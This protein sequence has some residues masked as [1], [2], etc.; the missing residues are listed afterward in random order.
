MKRQGVGLIIVTASV[1]GLLAERHVG[2]AYVATK[3]AVV[4]LVRHAAIELAEYGVCV[5]GIAPGPILTNIAG[6]KLKDPEVAKPYIA[7]VPMARLGDTDELKGLALLLGSNASS[8]IPGAPIPIDGGMTDWCS[9]HGFWTPNRGDWKLVGEGKS[10]S[11][12]I[13]L[14]GC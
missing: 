13:D 12:R 2:Y 14:G 3:A 8:F 1:A 6:G 5:D 9:L 10:V 7:N 4:N 11:V